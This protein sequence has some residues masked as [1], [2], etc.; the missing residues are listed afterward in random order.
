MEY[1]KFIR[2]WA[3][4]L[5]VLMS[6]NLYFVSKNF[7][8][9]NSY[10]FAPSSTNEK[11]FNLYL[12]C[13]LLCEKVEWMNW[14]IVSG[15]NY[16]GNSKKGGVL[17]SNDPKTGYQ[18]K[19]LNSIRLFSNVIKP[20]LIN[21]IPTPWMPGIPGVTKLVHRL[22]LDSLISKNELLLL[23]GEFPNS[24]K[25]SGLQIGKLR[26]YDK[27]M[28]QLSLIKI[29]EFLQDPLEGGIFSP[30]LIQNNGTELLFTVNSQSGNDGGILILG[31]IPDSAYIIEVEHNNEISSKDDGI[32]INVGFP[33]CCNR[34]IKSIDTVVCEN[35]IINGNLINKS[36]IF[37]DTIRNGSC[38]SII[39]YNITIFNKSILNLGND[40]IICDGELLT[41]K[42][43]S[44]LTKWSDGMIGK[45]ILVSRPGLYWAETES[46]CGV[47]R[48]SIIINYIRKPKLDLG[49]DM[50]YC[51]GVIDTIWSKDSNTIWN[52]GSKGP[53]LVIDHEGVYFGSLSND[54]FIASD[55]INVV[56]FEKV[57]LNLGPD[58]ILCEGEQDTVFSPYILKWNDGTENNFVIVNRTGN[59]W[60]IK[61]TPCGLETD[62]FSCNV[63]VKKIK[64]YLANDTSICLNTTLN[65][66][67]PLAPILWN[68][69]FI[70]TIEV[71]IPGIYSYVYED[72]C[73]TI[74][75]TILIKWDSFPIILDQKLILSCEVNSI[76]LNSGIENVEWS[77]GYIGRSIRVK[78]PGKYSYIVNNSC[79]LF[80][81]EVEVSFVDGISIDLPNVFS[82][83]GDN[84]ND[85][86]P[87][88]PFP[89]AFYVEIF[90]RWGELIFKGENN[91]WD[92]EFLNKKVI[93][94]V[95]VYVF[96]IEN[97]KYLFKYG[98]ITIVK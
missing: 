96:S 59:Y 84:I 54:C 15:F 85:Y 78:E 22:I 75:D 33:D 55:T 58:I 13:S 42:A 16:R 35:I 45:E 10:E 4:T 44:E 94:G 82:P 56:A 79:G 83:N 60:G 21:N 27:F 81:S 28:N 6:G 73:Q 5:L 70:N 20:K 97:C 95:Y 29:C 24:N 88:K 37:S 53:Y 26:I 11:L 69:I 38:D 87:P 76:I 32:Y 61:Y 57:N 67:V 63:L 47:L 41:L 46:P 39:N 31:N 23:L 34:I 9:S 48:D 36:S 3:V 77:T 7:S 52:D 93:P 92:G 19:Y 40:T 17:L 65:L 30:I 51:L 12:P 71:T 90:D 1:I 62:T 2:I 50:I 72:K 80:S 91:Y 74:S 25:Y 43:I 86:F 68:K 89:R 66:N 64:P 18:H 49:H 8:I 98:T 14:N